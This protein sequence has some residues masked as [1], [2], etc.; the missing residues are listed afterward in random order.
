MKLPLG[1]TGIGDRLE[2]S[3]EGEYSTNSDPK[4]VF[5]LKKS[6]Y[7]LKQAPRQWFA[8]L[9]SALKKNKFVQS[10]ADYSISSPS[11]AKELSQLYWCMLMIW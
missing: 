3:P 5:K 11:N 6:L 4:K 1:Y 8:K 2:V 9:S 10:K 7:G